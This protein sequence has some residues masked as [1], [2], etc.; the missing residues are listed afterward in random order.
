MRLIID[1]AASRNGGVWS[2]VVD[3]SSLL[4]LGKPTHQGGRLSVVMIS[5]PKYDVERCALQFELESALLL[6]LGNSNEVVFLDTGEPQIGQVKPVTEVA[7]TRKLAEGDK[8]FLEELKRLAMPLQEIGMKLMAAIRAEF[9]GALSF[10]PRSKKFVETPDNFWVARVQPRVQSIRIVI[11][12]NPE[13]HV[14]YAS[15]RLVP[16]MRSYSSFVVERE[17]QL[18]DAISAVRAAQHL[19]NARR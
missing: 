16:D 6:N 12:G 2:A 11:Y 17:E 8:R 4:R 13:D 9:P 19:R 7:D 15:I 14:T 10:H 18:A 5:N 1:N 3:P